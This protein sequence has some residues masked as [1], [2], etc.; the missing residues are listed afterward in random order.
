MGAPRSY[1]TQA[2][3]IKQFKLGEADKVLTIYTP[4]FGKLRAVAKGACRPGSKL[5]GNVEPLTH[6]SMMLARGRNLDIVTQSQ[7]VD[8]FP[9]LKSDLWGMA[10]GLYVL[11]LVDCFTVENNENRPV[12]ELLLSALKWLGQSGDKE[13]VLRYF[14]LQLLGY[15]GYRPELYNCGICG[16]PIKAVV[17]VFGFDQGGVLCP[18]CGGKETASRSLSVDALKTLR[19]WQDCDYATARRVVLKPQLASELEQVMQGYIRCLLQ[20]EVRSVAWLD[21]LRRTEAC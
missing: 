20:R 15:L 14:E 17:N 4:E 13:I 6:S 5:G 8:V 12:F 10:C 11:D 21:E 18:R 2:V 7:T 19:L 1:R 16:S 9:E 3:I